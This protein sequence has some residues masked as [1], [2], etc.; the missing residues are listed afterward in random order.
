MEKHILIVDDN[1]SDLAVAES[2]CHKNKRS[3]ICVPDGYEAIEVLHD[4][5]LEFELMI[6]DLQMP[7]MTGIELLKRMKATAKTKDVPV[8]IM[9]GR[10]ADRDVTMAIKLGASDYIVKPIDSF[11]FEEKI[12]K[13]LGK[14]DNTWKEYDIP[15]E[16]ALSSA[17]LLESLRI[18]KLSEINAE[19]LIEK[20][21]VVG[22]I[23]KFFSPTLGNQQ[24]T[25]TV[26]SVQKQG[27]TS[28]KIKIR[29]NGIGET[30]RQQIREACKQVWRKHYS[31]MAKET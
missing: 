16:E 10:K 2:I 30:Q 13:H 3:S 14:S 20:E 12:L 17:L 7:N 23:I 4:E 27:E 9:S 22:D 15:A 18:T 25:G 19:L 26:E 8:I 5:E 24:F 31:R 28:F 21:V 11:I 6:I 29:F 1:P